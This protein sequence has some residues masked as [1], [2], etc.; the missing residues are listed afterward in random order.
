M[1]FINFGANEPL[2]SLVSAI[3][4]YN[5][6]RAYLWQAQAQQVCCHTQTLKSLAQQRPKPE[7]RAFGS[8]LARVYKMQQQQREPSDIHNLGARD[9]TLAV[10]I[11][12]ILYLWR[13]IDNNR[14][15][16]APVEQRGVCLSWIRLI[17]WLALAMQRPRAMLPMLPIQHRGPQA[18]S[19]PVAN[20][21]ES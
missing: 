21:D 16:L 4:S 8:K 10:A 1:L 13:N 14:H 15:H 5:K 7:A 9:A 20:A 17:S 6:H 18:S 3:S 11:A 12:A 19:Q 2:Q